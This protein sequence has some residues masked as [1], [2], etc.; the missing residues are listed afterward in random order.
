M[1]PASTFSP[2]TAQVFEV[3]ALPRRYLDSVYKLYLAYQGLATILR[4][5][6]QLTKLRLIDAVTIE[7]P[8]DPLYHPGDLLF[9]CTPPTLRRS[10]NQDTS[11]DTVK[12][13]LTRYSPFLTDLRVNKGTAPTNVLASILLS[14]ILKN[15][16]KVLF[17]YDLVLSELIASLLMR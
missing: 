15:I 17:E 16:A 4:R 6:P 12:N 9:G 3:L 5:Y 10:S 7:R 2:G 13:V 14:N 8:M 11:P 1:Y